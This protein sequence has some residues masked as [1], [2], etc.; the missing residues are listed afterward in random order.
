MCRRG[1][2]VCSLHSVTLAGMAARNSP[3]PD[4]HL[5]PPWSSRQG[6]PDVG[7][8]PFGIDKERRGRDARCVSNTVPREEGVG[9]GRI[10]RSCP[11]ILQPGALSRTG[12]HAAGCLI[13]GLPN[14]SI[15]FER[16]SREEE[17][18]IIRNSPGSTFP[19]L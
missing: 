11:W 6:S 16:M 18:I 14:R 1:I 13:A 17:P 10:Q 4:E 15:L 9:R 5:L 19:S 12:A 8:R 3:P 7:I 2:A